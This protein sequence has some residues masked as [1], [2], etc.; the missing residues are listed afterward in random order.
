MRFSHPH[1]YSHAEPILAAINNDS[2]NPNPNPEASENLKR[3]S[4]LSSISSAST[5]NTNSKPTDEKTRI[6]RSKIALS[7]ITSS[8]LKR[9]QV[10]NSTLSTLPNVKWSIIKDSV[11]TNVL[12]LK[13]VKME[14]ATV[15]NVVYIRRATIMKSTI[16]DVV[17]VKKAT[18]KDSF[19]QRVALLE[20][21][22]LQNCV[23]NDCIIYKT[24]FEGI[25]LE[26]GIWKDG[27]LVGR[28]NQSKEVVVR[29]LEE[30]ESFRIERAGKHEDEKKMQAEGAGN[31]S[32]VKEDN[33]DNEEALPVYKS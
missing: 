18:V 5:I 2:P 24:D 12:T 26:N 19:L 10:V 25:R 3:C 14:A 13:R 17:R 32:L 7:S 29:A 31:D 15:S 33:N 23:V 9:C 20:R 16:S 27:C 1:S 4:S 22:T 30:G 21:S 6:R 8:Y 11:L 28:V